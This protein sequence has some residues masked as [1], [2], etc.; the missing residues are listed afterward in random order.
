MTRFVV[1]RLLAML[2]VMFAVSLLT[3]LLFE[4]IPNGDPA[5][6]LAG[7][8]A[9]ALEIHQIDIKYGFDKPIIVQYF[10]MMKNIFTCQAYS[11]TQGFNI[12]DEIKAGFPATLSL[13]L[14]AGIIWLL[15][16]IVVGTIAAIKAGR[17]TDRVLTVVAMIGV[18]MPPFFLGAVLIYYLGYEAE[19][20]PAR[21]LRALTDSPRQWFTHMVAAVVHAVGAVHRLLLAGPAGDDPRHDQRGLRAHR[22]RQGLVG[23]PGAASA[24]SCAT[25]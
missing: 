14:G 6:R 10:R 9:T 16:S 13:A 19:P 20:D 22:P 11:Y 3:F 2:L 23:A 1:R 17:Y 15:V 12:C 24:T 25:R 21:R 18:S 8:K 4:A 5:L 7:R